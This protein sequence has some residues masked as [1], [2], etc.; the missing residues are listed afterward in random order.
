M[1]C[2][3]DAQVRQ[4]LEVVYQRSPAIPFREQ[5][6]GFLRQIGEALVQELTRDRNEPRISKYYNIEGK[7]FWHVYDP[8]SQQRLICQSE[9]EVL[10]WLEDRYAH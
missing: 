2:P 1:V 8:R 3:N 10:A 6:W 4:Q 7:A 9:N 5:F